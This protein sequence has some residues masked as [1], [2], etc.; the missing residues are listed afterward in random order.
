MVVRPNALDLQPTTQ[1]AGISVTFEPDLKASVAAAVAAQAQVGPIISSYQTQAATFI[2]E[3]GA[4]VVGGHSP[5]GY[6]SQDIAGPSEVGGPSN[7][8]A[9]DNA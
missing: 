6:S 8:G 1:N 4:D 3:H 9:S 2:A 5:V 7:S